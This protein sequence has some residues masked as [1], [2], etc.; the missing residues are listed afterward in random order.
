MT[1]MTAMH[2]IHNLIIIITTNLCMSVQVGDGP[3]E[4][5]ENTLDVH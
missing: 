3:R 1:A 4:R 2:P 5:E